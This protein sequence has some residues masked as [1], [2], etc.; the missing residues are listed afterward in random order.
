[1][2]IGVLCEGE[3]SDAPALGLLLRA[4]FPRHTLSVLGTTKNAIFSQ[5]GALIDQLL[6]EGC[7][8]VVV[9]WDLHPV[10]VQMA[11]NSQTDAEEACRIDQQRTLLTNALATAGSCAGDVQAL[12]HR[13]EFV[14]AA[15]PPFPTTSRVALVCFA[16]SFDA[17]FL[18]DP[19]ILESLASSEIRKAERPPSLK[20]PHTQPKPQEILR[21][22]FGKGH[23]THLKFFNKAQHNEVLAK[24]F[25]AKARLPKLRK[26]PGY[27]RLAK[28]IESWV[29]N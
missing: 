2:K 11:T 25:V 23:N 21:R 19:T 10:G 28:L 20:R 14:A 16:H 4:E 7:E 12:Q 24:E 9:V 8:R 22:Y 13:Y 3:L 27:A 5:G 1:M 18:C 29:G 6:A 15:N 26:H 17:V